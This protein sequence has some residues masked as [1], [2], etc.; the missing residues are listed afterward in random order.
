MAL[1]HVCL[2]ADR[3][4]TRAPNVPD[5]GIDT[6]LPP[7]S[8]YDLGTSIRKQTRGAFAD[9]AARAGNDDDF[10][11][12]V[13]GCHGRCSARDNGPHR[14]E[15]RTGKRSDCTMVFTRTLASVTGYVGI[16]RRPCGLTP[17]CAPCVCRH[18]L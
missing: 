2:E 4:A 3:V 15:Q 13:R 9:A 10:P 8:E 14:V 11:S 12:D 17:S 7:R 6:I 18:L 1:R 16:W 5:E